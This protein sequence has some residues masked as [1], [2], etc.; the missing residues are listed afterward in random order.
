MQKPG[1]TRSQASHYRDLHTIMM[2][3]Y[4]S[5]MKRGVKKEIRERN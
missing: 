1:T 5:E 4:Q 2:G 3:L